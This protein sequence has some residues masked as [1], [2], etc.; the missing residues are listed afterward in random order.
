MFKCNKI[1]VS[2]LQGF[3]AIMLWSTT[4]AF[5]RSIS[6]NLGPFTSGACI[7]LLAGSLLYYSKYFKQRSTTKK[8]GA[9]SSLYIYGCGALFLIYTTSLYSALSLA[10]N[11]EQTLEVGLINYLWPGLTVLFSIP[12]LGKKARLGL[13][14]GTLIALAGVFLAL[15]QGT[16]FNLSSISSNIGRTPL[17]YFLGGVAAISWALYS[18][19]S[20]RWGGSDSDG[21]VPF[22]SLATGLLFLLLAVFFPERSHWDQHVILEILIFSSATAL[23]YSSWDNAMRKGNM[24]LVAV[25][26]YFIPLFSTLVSSFY[27]G[28]SPTPILWLGCIFIILGSITCW[29][30]IE[31]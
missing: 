15:T 19:F 23:A 26:S 8:P 10:A 3:L 4:I 13:I 9:S 6:E 18:N 28:V 7:Y 1:Q 2:T 25:G 14:P 17:P 5:A 27:L 20:C 22:F 30:S 21:A 24:I 29:R 31:P 12:I 16:S 11:H